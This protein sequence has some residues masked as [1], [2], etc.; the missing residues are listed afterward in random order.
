M[1][2]TSVLVVFCVVLSAASPSR[3]EERTACFF[4]KD[5]LG[6]LAKPSI[7]S[8]AEQQEIADRWSWTLHIRGHESSQSPFRADVEF[9]STSYSSVPDEVPDVLFRHGS[10]VYSR[11][12][13][14]SIGYF[15]EGIHNEG[16]CELLFSWLH[17][18]WPQRLNDSQFRRV[19]KEIRADAKDLPFEI[20]QED[21][22][23]GPLLGQ[24][25]EKNGIWLVHFILVEATSVIEYKYAIDKNNRVARL[26]RILVEGPEFPKEWRIEDPPRAIRDRVAVKF[27][28]FYRSQRLVERAAFLPELRKALESPS[29]DDRLSACWRIANI[30]QEA[31]AAVPE[32]RKVLTDPDKT[33]RDAAT[34]ALRHIGPDAKEALPDLRATLNDKEPKV[35]EGAAY[36]LLEI[37]SPELRI[38][39]AKVVEELGYQAHDS[40]IG[41]GH[42]ENDENAEVKAAAKA[43]LEKIRQAQNEWRRQFRPAPVLAVPEMRKLLTGSDATRRY[44]TAIALGRIGPDAKDAVPELGEMVVNDGRSWGRQYSAWALGKIGPAAETALP[45]LRKALADPNPE[46]RIA[47]AEAIDTIQPAS[48][49]EVKKALD[50][51]NLHAREKAIGAL[52]KRK[53]TAEIRKRLVGADT[54][55]RLAVMNATKWVADGTQKGRRGLLADMIPELKKALDDKSELV[56]KAAA[57]ALKTIGE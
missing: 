48:E 1:K 27:D 53:D 46:V 47:A 25:I 17:K 3:C 41:L 56:R 39:A 44:K 43:A 10:R 26:R 16:Q 30:K 11:I 37:G 13:W 18:N 4:G 32:L 50:D 19:I 35:R 34:C 14:D 36:A 9:G 29:R 40:M 55:F 2:T 52:L 28:H 42:A 7:P 54:D 57:E 12:V 23:D 51:K 33:I 49:S 31:R 6:F 8:E 38:E 20:F 24:C 5:M 15:L 45:Q 21:V 22:E